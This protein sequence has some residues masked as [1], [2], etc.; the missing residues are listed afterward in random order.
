M[1]G[2]NHDVYKKYHNLFTEY[3]VSDSIMDGKPTY[4]SK[5]GKYAIAICDGKWMVQK[6][7][8][9]YESNFTPCCN[10]LIWFTFQV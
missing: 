4:I 10:G 8:N 9:L 7:E 1:S 3:S 6:E 5:D 2:G